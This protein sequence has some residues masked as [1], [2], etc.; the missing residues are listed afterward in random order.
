[1]ISR[2]VLSDK[3]SPESQIIADG[4]RGYAPF[5]HRMADLDKAEDNIVGCVK[6]RNSGALVCIYRQAA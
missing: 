3:R 4:G 2:I 6:A 5:A 1:L